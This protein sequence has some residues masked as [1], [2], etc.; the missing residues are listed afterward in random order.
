MC[1]EYGYF[2]RNFF[3]ILINYLGPNKNK[4][5]KSKIYGKLTT[6]KLIILSFRLC[7]CSYSMYFFVWYYLFYEF[8]YIN[9]VCCLLKLLIIVKFMI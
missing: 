9:T 8:C 3:Y 4:Y 2:I 5:L 7:L 6:I 1:N